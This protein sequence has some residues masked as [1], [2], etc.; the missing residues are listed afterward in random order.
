MSTLDQMV[1]PYQAAWRRRHVCDQRQGTRNRVSRRPG[2]RA[3]IRIVLA[4]VLLAAAGCQ[5]PS[6]EGPADSFGLDFTMPPSVEVRGTVLFFVDGV[7][8]QIFQ[9]MLQK[10]ELPALKKYFVDRGLYC[11][12]AVD[13]LPSVTLPNETSVVTG[14]F[15]GHH[16]LT[17]NQWFDREILV[18]RDYDTVAQKNKLDGD[19]TAPT[20]FEQFPDRTTLSLF[21]QAHRGATRFNENAVYG[22]A[23]Y[24]M[25]WF[26]YIDRMTLSMFQDAIDLARSTGRFPAVTVCYLLSPDFAAYHSGVDT[27]EYRD[28]L[29]H[30]D[31]QVGRVLG[32]MQRAGL[33]DKLVLALVSDHGHTPTPKHL[34]LRP[35]YATRRDWTWRRKACGNRPPSRPAR[36]PTA[37]TPRWPP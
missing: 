2:G 21:F 27:E 22:A 4:G 9:E 3:G 15:P 34:D 25:G 35:S 17:G 37:S 12:R 24:V 13:S 29:R 23:S 30:T 10:G 33:L 11:P 14:V 28:S 26:E 20:L 5:T 6:A 8:A 31:R 7:N 1:E 18:F 32:D 36:R 19:F 16:G